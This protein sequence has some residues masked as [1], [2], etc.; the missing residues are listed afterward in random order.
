MGLLDTRD[1]PTYSKRLIKLDSVYRLVSKVMSFRSMKTVTGTPAHGI[2]L[3]TYH[4]LVQQGVPGGVKVALLFASVLT[5]M[6]L[7]HFLL[8]K[9]HEYKKDPFR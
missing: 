1:P 4:L 9:R 8:A 2:R 5:P 7:P 6:L 3:Y